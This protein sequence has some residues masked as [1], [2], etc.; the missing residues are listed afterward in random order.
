[1][2]TGDCVGCLGSGLC[3]VCLGTGYA[4]PE[5]RRGRCSRCLGTRRCHVCAPAPEVARRIPRR[6][7]VVDDEPDVLDLLRVWL[8]DDERCCAVETVTSGDA[9]LLALAEN[10][11]DTIVCDFQLGGGATSADYLPGFRSACPDARIVLHTGSPDLALAAGVI[12]RG[13]DLVLEKGRVTLQQ[14]IDEALHD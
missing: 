8:S 3:W 4:V 13:A 9:A 5:S 6:V 7:L 10:C 14:L 1:V 11:A 12:E 2:P